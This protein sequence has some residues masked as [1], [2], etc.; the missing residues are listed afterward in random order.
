VNNVIFVLNDGGTLHLIEATPSAYRLLAQ[1]K[2][3]EG[4][5]SWAPMAFADGR[6]LA[7]DL[8]EMVCLDVAGRGPTTVSAR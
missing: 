8:H 2:V 7:R 3:L 1:A 4:P 6:L 5:E